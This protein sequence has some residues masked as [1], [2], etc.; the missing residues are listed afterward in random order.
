MRSPCIVPVEAARDLESN[1]DAREVE[2]YSDG[3]KTPCGCLRRDRLG[4]QAREVAKGIRGHRSPTT[5][6][7]TPEQA[8]QLRAA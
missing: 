5:K 2:K 1:S 7:W 4:Y 3:E 8:L 6:F